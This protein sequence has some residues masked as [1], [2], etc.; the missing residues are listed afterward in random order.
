MKDTKYLVMPFGLT[1]APSTFQ[2][3]MNQVLGPYLRRFALVFFDDISIYSNNMEI[4]KQHLAGI[5]QTLKDNQLFAKQKKC[6][7]GQKQIEYLGH[8]ISGEGVSADP[9]KIEDMFKWPKPKDIKELRGFLGLTGY[10]RKFIKNYGRIAW[11]LTQLLKD[12]FCWND[13]SQFAFEQLKLAMTTLPVLAVPNFETEFNAETDA[14]GKGIGAVLMQEGRPVAYMSQTL[15]D[16]AQKKS[17]YER[18]L[19]AIVLAIQKW[20]PYLLGRHFQVHTDQKSL[21]FL[22]NQRVMGQQ[23]WTSTLL[24]YDFDIKY[25]P[26]KE[27]SEADAF[28]RHT[29]T[30]I[31]MDFIGGLPKV[32]G[33]DTAMVVVDRLT[34]YAHFVPVKHP[35]TAKDIADLFIRDIVKLHGFPSSIVSEREKT[36]VVNRCL[37]TY[38][39]CLTGR[40][41]KQWTRWLSWVEYWYNTNY[42]VSLKS[43]PFE[44]LYGKTPPTLIRGDV[45]HSAVEEVNRLTAERNDMLKEMQE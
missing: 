3:L 27:N 9:K 43:T 4:H 37:E 6:S 31:S 18:K 30:D 16:R 42:H 32:S 14:S 26:G 40:K 41:P 10:Y 34:K 17:V 5:L 8:L 1:N 35:Y 7:F 39:R 23:K 33:V 25:K 28:S 45:S 13:E 24:G 12:N 22:T 29:W 15:S 20:R 19:M 36:E 11:P 2:T 38:L 44:V 21:R